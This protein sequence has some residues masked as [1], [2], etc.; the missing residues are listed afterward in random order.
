MTDTQST[1]TSQPAR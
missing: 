1:P